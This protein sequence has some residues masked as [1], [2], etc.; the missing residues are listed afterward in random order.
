VDEFPRVDCRDD[1]RHRRS[2]RL[3]SVDVD[4]PYEPL[5]AVTTQ[6]VDK[7]GENVGETP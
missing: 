1:L 2:S 3:P 5:S 4:Q 6:P 7:T